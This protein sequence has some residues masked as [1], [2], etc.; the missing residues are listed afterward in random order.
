MSVT[1]LTWQDATDDE[2][3][4]PQILQIQPQPAPPAI[5][6]HASKP[7]QKP[8]SPKITNERVLYFLNQNSEESQSALAKPS[9]NSSIIQHHKLAKL[10]KQQFAKTDQLTKENSATVA[11]RIVN[12][13]PSDR[14]FQ[15]ANLQPIEPEKPILVEKMKKQVSPKYQKQQQELRPMLQEFAAYCM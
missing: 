14:L 11:N 7:A 4:E 8:A 13:K 15:S 5:Q 3:E 1:S 10:E 6:K 2:E 12:F 9:V